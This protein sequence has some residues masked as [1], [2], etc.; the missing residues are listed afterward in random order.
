MKEGQF[1][2][3]IYAAMYLSTPLLPRY[4]VSERSEVKMTPRCPNSGCLIE[5]AGLTRT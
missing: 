1:G 5:D 4:N 3:V 2:K